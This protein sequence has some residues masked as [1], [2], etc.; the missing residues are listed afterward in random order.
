M[1]PLAFASWKKEL[2]AELPMCF[3]R[4]SKLPHKT[5]MRYEVPCSVFLFGSFADI[6]LH[7]III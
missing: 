6:G 7:Y 2:V 5:A 3:A 4:Y 1:V